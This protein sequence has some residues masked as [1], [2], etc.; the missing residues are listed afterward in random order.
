MTIHKKLL[1]V[2]SELKAPKNQRNN[3][4]RFNYRSCEDIFEAVKP[5]LLK[6]G[7]LLLV[8]DDIINIQDR[9][10]VQATAEVVDIEDGT[11]ISVTASARESSEK[12]GMDLAQVTG[13]TSSYARKYAL[14]GLFAIDDTKDSDSTNTGS[15]ESVRV[16]TDTQIKDMIEI[17][18]GVGVTEE[19]VKSTIKSKFKTNAENMSQEQYNAILESL[20]KLK[21]DVK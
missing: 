21:G 18:K 10:Y 4:G 17:A 20:T 3:F 5:L 9:F 8:K 12:K 1:L 13:S 11:S 2:Q 6:H 15:G 7:L 19:Q 14:N 16:L